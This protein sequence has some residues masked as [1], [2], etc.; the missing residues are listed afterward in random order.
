M[1]YPR[2]LYVRVKGSGRGASGRASGKVTFKVLSPPGKGETELRRSVVEVPLTF[3]V[4]PT[5]SREKRILWSQYHSVRYPPGYVPRDNLDV[6][7]D[8]LDWQG[9]PFCPTP[10][11]REFTLSRLK[12]M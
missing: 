1:S 2:A 3:A 7:S 6:K 10:A 9:G 5:P 11:A 8:I 12:R 4:V